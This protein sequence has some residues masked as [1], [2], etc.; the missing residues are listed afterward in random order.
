MEEEV[1]LLNNYRRKQSSFL[2]PATEYLPHV[3]NRN[4]HV[5]YIMDFA[6]ALSETATY[7]AHR[8]DR[9]KL[10]LVKILPSS[11]FFY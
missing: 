3:P 1:L 7:I 11:V 4:F 8:N 5:T 6:G 9:M 2:L 10:V